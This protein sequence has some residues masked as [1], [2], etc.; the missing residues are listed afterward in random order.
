VSDEI[1]EEQWGLLFPFVVC[2]SND[3][4]Y[5]DAAFV[6]GYQAGRID[7]SLAV[8]VAAEADALRFTVH[9]LLV[10]QLE[11][12]AMNHGYLAKSEPW[13]QEPDLWSF[14]TFTRV[15]AEP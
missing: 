10:P 4:P 5:D 3:G 13:E 12:I 1:S 8:A 7:R 9:T 6:A 2:Q 11:L 15:G 14:V